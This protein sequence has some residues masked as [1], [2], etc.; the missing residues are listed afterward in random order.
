MQGIY[1]D[2]LCELELE[3]NIW[4]IHSVVLV[5]WNSSGHSEP[6]TEL[7]LPQKNRLSNMRLRLHRV[8]YHT[9]Y[10]VG[11]SVLIKTSFDGRTYKFKRTSSPSFRNLERSIPILE[12]H[13]D[14]HSKHH[15]C[16]NSVASSVL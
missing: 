16:S 10:K 9:H 12:H 5:A 14:T 8:N 1:S 15:C 11:L 6:S 3:V 13:Y 7:D 4:N 2:Y